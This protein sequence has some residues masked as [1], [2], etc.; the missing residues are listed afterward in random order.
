[1]SRRYKGLT[2]ADSSVSNQPNHSILT[3]YI[4]TTIQRTHTFKFTMSANIKTSSSALFVAFISLLSTT[5]A[6]PVNETSVLSERAAGDDCKWALKYMP[7]TFMDCSNTWQQG[8]DHLDY[9]IKLTG[10]SQIQ[11]GWCKGI[12]DNIKGQC[13]N[14]TVVQGNCRKD[15][16]DTMVKALDG[17]NGWK[18][19][20]LYGIDMD[21]QVYW[22]WEPS[23]ADHACIATAAK[24]ASCGVEVA[25]GAHCYRQGWTDPNREEYDETSGPP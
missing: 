25:N 20:E 8:S 6:A 14:P 21:F 7:Y 10:T 24:I 2:F 4:I 1:M 22:P 19:L 17:D 3:P 13:G 11:D 16:P 23:D 9:S 5:I 18:Q 12:Y 15:N